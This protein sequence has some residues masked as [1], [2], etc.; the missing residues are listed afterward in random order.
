[1]NREPGDE[2]RD[3][4]DRGMPLPLRVLAAVGAFSFL[5]LGL[6]SLVPLLRMPPPAPP[7]PLDSRNLPVT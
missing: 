6:S 7:D 5:M 3:L 1:V 2:D 4:E